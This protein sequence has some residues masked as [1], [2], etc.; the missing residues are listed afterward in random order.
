MN[1]R[2][3]PALI[4]LALL[5]A[6]GSGCGTCSVPGFSAAAP[7]PTP[8]G[9]P[10]PTALSCAQNAV[11]GG[12]VPLGTAATFAVLAGSTVTNSGPTIV[13]GNLGVSPLTAITG[14]GPGEGTVIGGSIYAGGAIPAQAQL[15]LTT[16]Y[17]YAMTRAGA[18][19]IPADIG[20]ETIPPGIYKAPVSLV[21]PAT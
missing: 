14:F 10:P 15:D 9:G 21:S 3:L 4:A 18:K 11:S 20:G 7:S 19:S 12:S 2:I 8:V 13:T 1:A 5:N 17:N 16:A 6:C